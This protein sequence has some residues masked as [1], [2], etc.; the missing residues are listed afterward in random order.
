MSWLFDEE[1]INP[2]GII[3]TKPPPAPVMP[4]LTKIKKTIDIPQDSWSTASSPSSHGKYTSTYIKHTLYKDKDKLG[5]LHLTH[6]QYKTQ[7]K[8][9]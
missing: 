3:L 7:Y 9:F 6:L 1:E 8:T 2:P 4:S 5:K